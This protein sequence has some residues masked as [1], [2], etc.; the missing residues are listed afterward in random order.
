[1]QVNAIDHIV[2]NVTDVETSAVWYARALG[3]IRH[4]ALADDGSTRTSMAF[5]ANKINLRPVTASQHEWFTAR[6]PQAGSDD[7][8]FLSDM[9]P[10]AVLDHFRSL[11]ITIEQGPVPKKSAQGEICSIYVRDPDGNLIEVSSYK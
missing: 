5:G 2:F 8:C 6:S 9:P 11:G 3:M 4:D 1:M 10:N 7:L